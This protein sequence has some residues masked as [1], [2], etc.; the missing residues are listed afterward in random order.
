MK[1]KPELPT[2]LFPELT[3]EPELIKAPRAAALTLLRA[4]PRYRIPTANQRKNI[5]AAFMNQGLVLY[6]KAFDVVRIDSG[7]DLDS[8]GQIAR[9]LN[10]IVL[11]RLKASAKRMSKKTSKTKF[12][13][14]FFS[15]S[16][17]E[18]LM[19]QTLRERYKFVFV[20]TATEEYLELDL[21]QIFSRAKGMYPSW[22]IQ[23]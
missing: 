10:A 9:R 13:G 2:S 11:V 15:L 6:D 14:Y 16:A 4:D 20:N 5:V 18:L 23:F 22:G 1:S 12:D 19:A 21:K 17:T 8:P 3:H 7:L